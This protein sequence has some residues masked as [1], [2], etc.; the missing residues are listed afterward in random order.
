M[1]VPA[2][3]QDA[4]VS[5]RPVDS[6]GPVYLSGKGLG[7]GVNLRLKDVE[8]SVSFSGKLPS[9]EKRAWGLVRVRGAKIRRYASTLPRSYK[10]GF[11]GV[12]VTFVIKF[13]HVVLRFVNRETTRGK[14]D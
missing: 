7:F 8:F 4:G 12:T 6:T 10:L 5:L 14:H 13:R 2:I 9:W 3:A 1:S 11:R